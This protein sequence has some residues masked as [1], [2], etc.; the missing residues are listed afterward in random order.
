MDFEKAH[1]FIIQRITPETR[2][3]RMVESTE[4]KFDSTPAISSLHP[5]DTTSLESINNGKQSEIQNDSVDLW[6]TY[7]QGQYKA[8]A[9]KRKTKM[10]GRKAKESVNGIYVVKCC[11]GNCK[12][13][14]KSTNAMLCHMTTYHVIFSMLDCNLNR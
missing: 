4:T 11:R 9:L 13:R 5:L 1:S 2:A 7:N 14:F 10:N 6:S 12:K 3:E 8:V